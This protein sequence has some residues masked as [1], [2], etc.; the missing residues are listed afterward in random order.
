MVTEKLNNVASGFNK[1]IKIT[2][3]KI[4]GIAWY[5]LIRFLKPKYWSRWRRLLKLVGK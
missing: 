4:N 5:N 3:L 2:D 1:I